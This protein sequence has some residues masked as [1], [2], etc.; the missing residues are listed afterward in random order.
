MQIIK[1]ITG[2]SFIA[3]ILKSKDSATEYLKRFK[4]PDD[5]ILI[6]KPKITNFPFY[7]FERDNNFE[8]FKTK[9]EL[10]N[11]IS[12]FDIIEDEDYEYGTIFI[13][14]EEYIRDVPEDDDM[15]S[16]EH[17]HVGNEEVKKIENLV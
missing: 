11:W 16:L 15:G 17:I 13:I 10:T 12:K 14:E 7:I 5:F 4:N 2:R 1:K 9:E 6:S 3:G 8:Y